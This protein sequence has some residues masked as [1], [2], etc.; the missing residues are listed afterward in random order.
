[1]EEYTFENPE[2]VMKMKPTM[3]GIKVGIKRKDGNTWHHYT[4]SDAEALDMIIMLNRMR[5]VAVRM[6]RAKK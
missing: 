5:P 6:G 2:R 1:M 3:S 4:L